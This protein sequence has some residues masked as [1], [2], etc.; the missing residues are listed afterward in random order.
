MN[1]EKLT[2]NYSDDYF[3]EPMQ[4]TLQLALILIESVKNGDF[5]Y[6]TLFTDR[7]LWDLRYAVN[8]I[9]I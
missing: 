5:E 9:D 1:Y 2:K 4:K 6:D 3:C 7:L 8:E